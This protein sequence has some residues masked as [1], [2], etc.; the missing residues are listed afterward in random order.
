MNTVSASTSQVT[1]I[2]ANTARKGLVISSKSDSMLYVSTVNGFAKNNAPILIAPT[3]S[4]ELRFRYTGAFY[5]VWDAA[6][7]NATVTEY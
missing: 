4:W 7:G 3:E 1:L 6:A 2:A 5:G